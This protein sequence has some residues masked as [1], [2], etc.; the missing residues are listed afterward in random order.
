M[1]RKKKPKKATN[2]PKA[3]GTKRAASK[4]VESEPPTKKARDD[5]SSQG[6]G[7]TS[8][9]AATD[10]ED[11][12]TVA[13]DKE[14]DSPAYQSSNKG[15]SSRGNA[16]GN[17][18]T[19]NPVDKEIVPEVVNSNTEQLYP[20]PHPDAVD[21]LQIPHGERMSILPSQLVTDQQRLR[22]AQVAEFTNRAAVHSIVASSLF[23]RVKFLDP[24]KDLEFTKESGTICEFMLARCKIPANLDERD[25]WAKSKKW[26][27]SS[28]ARLR[29]DKTS[30]IRDE[31]FGKCMSCGKY[32]SDCLYSWY[33]RFEV[34]L[35]DTL[36]EDAIDKDNH[37][38]KVDTKWSI[39]DMLEGRMNKECY[40]LYFTRF[41]PILEKKHI[42]HQ[43][44]LNAKTDRDVMSISSEAFGL[45]VLENQ[46]DRWIDIY[47]RSGGDIV[48]DK[49]F[50]LKDV[51]STVTPKFTRGGL[52]RD[53]HGNKKRTSSSDA[54]KGWSA[55]GIQRFNELYDLVA[56]DRRLNPDF[57][58]EWLRKMKSTVSS[59]VVKKKKRSLKS[60][61]ACGQWS[62]AEVEE[63]DKNSKK[64]M[65]KIA[66]INKKVAEA[67][68][69]GEEEDESETESSV[70][71]SS[72]AEE[73]GSESDDDNSN[74]S[75][76]ELHPSTSRTTKTSRKP[77]NN[78]TEAT[79]KEK[80]AAPRKAT[81]STA[82][83]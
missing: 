38:L 65:E 82:N 34:W 8:V 55:Q 6:T 62:L 32:I 40:S 18:G 3:S 78:D 52:A 16:T 28:I 5:S 58:T 63:S 83:K 23:P 57:F 61:E 51:N 59:T 50:R 43:N 80:V 24:V 17:E 9:G 14:E 49:N 73:D 21:S 1:A 29:S 68:Q 66:M 48:T 81:R 53:E 25:F 7:K 72:S 60:N 2:K 4:E 56:A 13:G 33:S 79:A 19:T 41:A 77:T 75:E 67:Q 11:S 15:S 26:V 69:E 45:L 42:W 76:E 36:P 64:N 22:T 35:H 71:G 27:R 20:M 47:V 70:E 54:M 10:A 74:K 30:A 39:D 37:R 46:W 12:V 44:L 31:F